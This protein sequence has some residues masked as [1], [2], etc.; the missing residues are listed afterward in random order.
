[1]ARYTVSLTKRDGL[2]VIELADSICEASASI[3]PDIGGNLLRFNRA[4]MRCWPG[5]KTGQS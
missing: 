2:R 1:M 5:R 4:D 3:L